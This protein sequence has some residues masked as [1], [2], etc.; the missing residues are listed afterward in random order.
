MALNHP[1]VEIVVVETPT[2]EIIE[3]GLAFD[4][5]DIAVLTGQNAA[6]SEEILASEE[7]LRQIAARVIV[8]SPPRA[9]DAARP[10]Y[11][12]GMESVATEV[13]R[14]LSVD[15]HSSPPYGA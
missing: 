4:V 15:A 11:V 7:L 14:L 10:V 2:A 3:Q 9:I 5:C 13:A 12:H 1:L 8:T 6:P